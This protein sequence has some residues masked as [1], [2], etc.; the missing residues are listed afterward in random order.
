MGNHSYDAKLCRAC[1]ALFD[2]SAKPISAAQEERHM[3]ED[4]TKWYDYKKDS[5]H[6]EVG[7]D[8]FFKMSHFDQYSWLMELE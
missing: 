8:R 3:L 7:I 1:Q 5:N 2:G 6:L 4:N